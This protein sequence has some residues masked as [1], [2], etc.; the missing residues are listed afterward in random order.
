MAE[1]T[2]GIPIVT[3]TRMVCVSY[4]GIFWGKTLS[5][6]GVTTDILMWQTLLTILWQTLWI[7]CITIGL[8]IVEE[9]VD[10]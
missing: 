3:N 5:M 6:D 9:T 1:L 10:D 8:S 2:T 7:V 4:T